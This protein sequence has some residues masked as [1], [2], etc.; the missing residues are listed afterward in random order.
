VS[1]SKIS[2]AAAVMGLVAAQAT[3]VLE[4]LLPGDGEL[5]RGIR[6]AAA[7]GAALIALAAAARLLR[8]QEFTD[9]RARVLRRLRPGR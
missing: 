5:E 9:A 8:I 6:V 7:I 2:V 4:R 1:L 3:G